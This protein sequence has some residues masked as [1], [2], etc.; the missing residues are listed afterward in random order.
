MSS[1]MC[2]VIVKN[3]KQYSIRME[4]VIS[5]SESIRFDLPS[6]NC[7]FGSMAAG[8]LLNSPAASTMKVFVAVSYSQDVG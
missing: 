3:D 1:F 5:E 4:L 7:I 6:G 8:A 2:E